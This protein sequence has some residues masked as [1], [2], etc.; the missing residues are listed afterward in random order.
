MS[1]IEMMDPKMDAGMLCNRGV[2]K[3]KS[4]DQAVAVRKF[5]NN[6]DFFFKHFLFQDGTLKLDNFSYE[7]LIGII[8]TTFACIVSWLE[9]HSLA[10]TVFTNLYL[11]K[12]YNVECRTLKAFS[13]IVYKLLEIIKDFIHK[14]VVCLGF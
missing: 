9:G 11:H 6:C 12:P 5:N 10:Q 7:E 8:D 4:F 13:L 2:K 1:A 3:A 14:Y